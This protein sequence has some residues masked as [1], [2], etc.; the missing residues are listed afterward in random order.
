MSLYSAQEYKSIKKHGDGGV[1][2][3]VDYLKQYADGKLAKKSDDDAYRSITYEIVAYSVQE[4]I[5][6]VFQNQLNRNLFEKSV[7]L[8][9]DGGPVKD[10]QIPVYNIPALSRNAQQSLRAD[11][12][13]EYKQI[14]AANSK[15][16]GADL[17][18]VEDVT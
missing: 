15:K 8:P 5:L 16:Y 4:A 7:L 13:K 9:I 1:L 14:L 11:F 12:M 18:K 2:F 17:A 3:L 10:G 6:K